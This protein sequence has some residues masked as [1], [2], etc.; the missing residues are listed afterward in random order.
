M[1]L[2]GFP[3]ELLLEITSYLRA[4]EIEPLAQ[5]FNQRLYAIC[6]PRLADRISNR[7]NAKLARGRFQKFQSNPHWPLGP[8]Y[9][10][11]TQCSMML[12]GLDDSYT[13]LASPSLRTLDNL[14]LQG[15][16]AWLQHDQPGA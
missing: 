5:T 1:S 7:R 14:D 3:T 2:L 15:D 16:L 10:C 11:L 6:L 13:Y 12:L 4:F 9:Y 8:I